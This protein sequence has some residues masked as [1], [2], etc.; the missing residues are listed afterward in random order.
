METKEILASRIRGLVLRLLHLP[1]EVY[2][3]LQK[4][5]I[6]SSG[7]IKTPELGNRTSSILQ[8]LAEEF[9]LVLFSLPANDNLPKTSLSSSPGLPCIVNFPRLSRGFCGF[10]PIGG[11]INLFLF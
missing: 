11:F 4:M 7:G 2:L 10:H 8:A 6:V 1:G 9:C 5:K 3:L